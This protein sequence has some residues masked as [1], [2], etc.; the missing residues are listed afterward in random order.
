[1]I[2]LRYTGGSPWVFTP[3]D[4]TNID[5]NRRYSDALSGSEW[6]MKCDWRHLAAYLLADEVLKTHK[7]DISEEL[8]RK[9]ALSWMFEARYVGVEHKPIHLVLTDAMGNVRKG[10]VLTSL[11]SSSIR[12]S[13]LLGLDR[14]LKG[15]V[16]ENKPTDYEIVFRY[17]TVG[18]AP[19]ESR[20]NT[21]WAYSREHDKRRFFESEVADI[22][23]ILF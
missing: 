9:F 20:E 10:I 16:R 7:Y 2:Q 14:Y 8:P 17:T 23:S 6:V 5:F 22:E 19:R 18:V 15:K 12:N 11:I 3:V 21:L 1:M 4:T 13:L